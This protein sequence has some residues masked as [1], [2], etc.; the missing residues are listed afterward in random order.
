MDDNSR[1]QDNSRASNVVPMLLVSQEN[2][3]DRRAHE[4]QRVVFYLSGGLVSL[5]FL[6][7]LSKQIN[8]SDEALQNAPLAR[9]MGLWEGQWN[10]ME[11]KFALSG[12]QITTYETTRIFSSSTAQYQSGVVERLEGDRSLVRQIWLTR[13]DQDGI[14]RARRNDEGTEQFTQFTG[15]KTGDT[16]IWSHEDNDSQEMVRL[17]LN[18]PVLTVEELHIS[19]SRPADSH[20]ITGRYTRIP[21]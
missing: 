16:M 15:T 18:G 12:A 6:L 4:I 2:L 14:L 20:L 8:P 3:R 21:Q 19:K 10:G 9:V 7:V 17:W 1:R 13:L 5:L 11:T